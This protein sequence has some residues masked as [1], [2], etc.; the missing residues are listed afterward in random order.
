MTVPVGDAIATRISRLNNNPDSVALPCIF[1]RVRSVIGLERRAAVE[2]Y[3]HDWPR[4]HRIVGQHLTPRSRE[5]EQFT[6]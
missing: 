1:Q 5:V 3:R 4:R 6:T 2:Q